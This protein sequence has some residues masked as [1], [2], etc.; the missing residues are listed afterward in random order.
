MNKQKP[1]ILIW[2]IE[3]SY[4]LVATF[5]LWKQNIPHDNIIINR[6][7]FCIAYRWYGEKKTHLI[8]ILDDPKR[9][10]K[11]HHDDS[12]V[13]TEFRKV[14]EQADAHVAHYGD[15]FDLPMFNT[16]LIVN[17][18]DP[19][20][21]IKSLDTL[22]I[23]KRHFNFNSNKL[24]YLAKFLGYKGKMDNPKG[25]WMRCFEGDKASLKHMGKYNKVDIDILEYVF[26]KLMPFVQ[27]HQL[28]MGMFLKG[29]RCPNPTCGS[30]NIEWRGYNYTR[31]SKYKRFVCKDCRG[32]SDERKAVKMDDK[33]EIK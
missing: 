7:I 5:G 15:G 6:H 13:V 3:S 11:D 17:G 1:K 18:L 21:K 10:K 16:R 25:L 24:D 28:N 27:N 30:T 12:Y 9:F 14:I 22:K 32:W 4:N 19:L 29:A 31:V 20:P 8:S 2:D 26:N 33:V 23:A